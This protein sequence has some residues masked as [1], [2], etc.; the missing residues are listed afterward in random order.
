L[1]E[2]LP[3]SRSAVLARFPRGL[4][5]AI[6]VALSI[7]FALLLELAGLPAALLLGP[8]IAAILIETN[9]GAIRVP[10]FL[11]FGAQ[12]VIGCLLFNPC[13]F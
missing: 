3:H 5:W 7:T 1:P 11:R 12:A 6:L 8:M 13:G 2:D 9:G 4:L 10:P